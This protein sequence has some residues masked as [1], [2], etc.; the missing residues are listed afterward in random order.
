MYSVIAFSGFQ[1]KVTPGERVKMPKTD[2]PVGEIITV[3]DVLL[4]SNGTEVKVGAPTVAGATVKLEILQH[5]RDDKIVVFKKKRRK[6]Y[7]RTA[8]HRQHYTEV[9][10][11]EMAC[12]SDKSVVDEAVVKRARVRAQALVKMKI[13]VKGPTRREKAL[14]AAKEN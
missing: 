4:F 7:R 2:K 13:Q 12:G 5:D 10:V 3:S 11:R 6:N 1:H 9:I 14:A 8:G